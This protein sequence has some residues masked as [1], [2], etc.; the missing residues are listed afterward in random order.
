[1]APLPKLPV[2]LWEFIVDYA[3]ASGDPVQLWHDLRPVSTSFRA[4][5]ENAFQETWLPKVIITIVGYPLT[6]D[7]RYDCKKSEARSHN[8]TAVFSWTADACNSDALEVDCRPPFGYV[9]EYQGILEDSLE[10]DDPLP[11]L[12]F[13]NLRSRSIEAHRQL[14][15]NA[16]FRDIYIS[17]VWKTEPPGFDKTVYLVRVGEEDTVDNHLLLK[18]TGL[19]DPLSLERSL[20]SIG[21]MEIC[22]DW[23]TMLSSAF[24]YHRALERR[25]NQE[26][27]DFLRTLPESIQSP[28]SAG[29]KLELNVR[30]LVQYIMNLEETFIET[31]DA[32]IRKLPAGPEYSW[33]SKLPYHRD[34]QRETGLH[35][36]RDTFR[37]SCLH[38][39]EFDVENQELWDDYRT[40]EDLTW[41]RY[42]TRHD[43]DYRLFYEDL[44]FT[45]FHDEQFRELLHNIPRE[46]RQ[47]QI[48][49]L[50]G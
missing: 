36:Y 8:S 23:V 21:N 46:E 34:S 38:V 3:V 11:S 37:P 22:V 44:P 47:Q 12:S 7:L 10:D 5:T 16:T 6:L 17:H 33:N 27:E 13:N 39:I 50:F 4:L 25:R 30:L 2:E 32:F 28:V 24:A 9:C 48:R 29:Q 15:Y 49:E 18:Y 19:L 14:H 31:R 20:L 40:V 35:C 42:Y 26:K 43:W 41:K 45:E 1:M